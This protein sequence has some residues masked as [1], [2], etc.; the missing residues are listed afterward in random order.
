M[1]SQWIAT[2]SEKICMGIVAIPMTVAFAMVW[3]YVIDEKCAHYKWYLWLM[4]GG[5][6]RN[7]NFAQDFFGKAFIGMGI[8][9]VIVPCIVAYGYAH[10]SNITIAQF[11]SNQTGG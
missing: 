3:L 9:N 1:I 2:N 8:A 7:E 6:E 4:Y 11:I 10:Y 5:A